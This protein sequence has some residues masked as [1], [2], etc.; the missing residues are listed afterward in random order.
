MLEVWGRWLQADEILKELP[1]ALPDKLFTKTTHLNETGVATYTDLLG[2]A[3]ER[4]LP[5]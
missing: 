5:K 3:L 4:S 1:P 2:Q